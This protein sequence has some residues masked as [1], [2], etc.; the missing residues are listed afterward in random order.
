MHND[1]IIYMVKKSISLKLFQ[2]KI[3]CNDSLTAHRISYI[4]KCFI[5]KTAAF[6]FE[7]V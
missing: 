3:F 2:D 5:L 7:S 4:E 1:A 6:P